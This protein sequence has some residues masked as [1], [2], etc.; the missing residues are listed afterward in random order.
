MPPLKQYGGADGAAQMHHLSADLGLNLFRLP[1]GWQYLTNS[2]VGGTLD[3][4]AFEK[5]DALVQA[6]LKTGASCI[7]DIHNYARWNKGIIGQGGPT[8]DQFANLWAQLGK[9]YAANEK[10]IFG[11]MN[12]PHEVPDI[13]RWAVS[14]QAAVTAIRKA[15]A[16]T[17]MITLPGNVY[18]S[19]GSF[20]SSKSGEAL[21][22]VKNLDG[23]TTNLIF[24][25]H[26]YLDK[27]FSGTHSA[28]DI[29]GVKESFTGLATWARAQKR[30]VL[31]AEIGGGNEQS[32]VTNLCSAFDYLNANSDVYL[33]WAGWSAG[34][35]D[36]TYVLKQTPKLGI[37][38]KWTD[39]ETMR[40]CIAGKFKNGTATGFGFE[41]I[42]DANS[43]LS[44][45]SPFGTGTA[46]SR[47][48][49]IR[50]TEPYWR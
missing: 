1:V 20:V 12:E 38:G 2:V 10:V 11:L 43:T 5:Y 49:P 7:I 25:V 24:E 18:T 14:V 3:E 19:A 41:P 23:S 45:N 29:D 15:G 36:G 9:A 48:K 40:Q 17:Q 27:D 47:L 26:Q 6:C 21:S 22:T 44:S 50:G 8:D 33:G 32:C 34:S 46:F 39:T 16:T 13:N 31:V 28:C 42:S 4:T 35:F 30:Q 37:N